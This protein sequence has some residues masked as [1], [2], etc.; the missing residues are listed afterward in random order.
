VPLNRVA[1]PSP[2]AGYRIPVPYPCLI[3][4][5]SY[6]PVKQK[7]TKR[8]RLWSARRQRGPCRIEELTALLASKQYHC[9]SAQQ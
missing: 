9:Q 8:L 2:A 1:P 3:Y 6:P 4:E 7:V 5:I